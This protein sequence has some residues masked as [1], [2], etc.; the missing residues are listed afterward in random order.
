MYFKGSA[1]KNGVFQDPP[2]LPRPQI[3]F[4]TPDRPWTTNDTPTF[5]S[6]TSKSLP[7]SPKKH[8]P[9]KAGGYD[10]F[11][12]STPRTMGIGAAVGKRNG[13]MVLT[14]ED[15]GG[16]TPRDINK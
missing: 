14:A 13:Y 3:D 15:V 5:A 9:T 16:R 6:Y 10:G 1:T 12:S 4:A 11:G 2:R 8:S 7:H